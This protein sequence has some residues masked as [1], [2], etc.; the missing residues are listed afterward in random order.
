MTVT[1]EHKRVVAPEL[2][3]VYDASASDL[4]DCEAQDRL[5]ADIGDDMCRDLPGRLQYAE[6]WDFPRGTAPPLSLSP[7]TKVGFV[8]LNFSPE[9]QLAVHRDSG[10][11]FPYRPEGSKDSRVGKAGLLRCLKRRDLQLEQLDD[12]EP[13][14]GRDTM[15]SDIA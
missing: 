9:K 8:C 10:D 6:Y 15:A 5:G 7:A 12:P 2:V 13:I 4:L 14:L 1:A 3:C 11:T